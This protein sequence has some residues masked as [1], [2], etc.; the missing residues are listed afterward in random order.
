[1]GEFFEA[2]KCNMF[3]LPSTL[4]SFLKQPS[5]LISTLSVLKYPHVLTFEIYREKRLSCGK[6]Y[7]QGTPGLCVDLGLGLEYG[8]YCLMLGLRLR[9]EG[10][11]E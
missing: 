1:L 7:W 4:P 3:S 5:F 2:S 10:V 6:T 8:F 9:G 11:G